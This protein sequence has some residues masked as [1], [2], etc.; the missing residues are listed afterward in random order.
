MMQLILITAFREHLLEALNDGLCLGT[1]R[2]QV[3]SC[4]LPLKEFT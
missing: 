3:R 1:M 2:V 4:G